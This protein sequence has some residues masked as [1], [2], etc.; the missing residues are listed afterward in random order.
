MKVEIGGE[1]RQKGQDGK[2][3]ESKRKGQRER[4]RAIR[5]SDMELIAVH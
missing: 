1:R 3:K 2:I 5:L 4:E